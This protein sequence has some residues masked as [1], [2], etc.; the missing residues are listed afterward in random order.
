[1][2]RDVEYARRGS[3]ALRLDLV[4][5]AARGPHAAIIVLHPGGWTSGSKEVM[6]GA[7]RTLARAGFAAVVPQYRLAPVHRFPAQVEDVRDAV[8]WVRGNAAQFDVDG[9]RIGAFGYSAGGHLAALVATWPA[10]DARIQAVAVGGAPV[11]LAALPANG[12]TRALLG[13]DAAGEGERY[14][15]ASPV[16]HVSADDPP[17]LVYHGRLDAMVRVGQARGL[18]DALRRVG[19]PTD[20]REGW[21]G[22]FTTFLVRGGGVDDAARF[23]DRWLRD[24]ARLAATAARAG[25]AG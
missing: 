23:F 5:P 8:R 14:A 6:T 3:E 12:R 19:V 25:E 18:R 10:P 9:E 15:L 22:H 4:L 11:D 17:F 21:L 24:P 20:Y 13:G 1:V 7:A 2:L 16:S